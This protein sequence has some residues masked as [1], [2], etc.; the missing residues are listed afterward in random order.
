MAKLRGDHWRDPTHGHDC[1]GCDAGASRLVNGERLQRAH[2]RVLQED[3]VV[4][5]EER[6]DDEPD[7]DPPGQCDWGYCDKLATQWRWLGRPSGSSWNTRP[8]ATLNS[9]PSTRC[10]ETHRNLRPMDRAHPSP[11]DTGVNAEYSSTVETW[12]RP[13]GCTC[14]VGLP[15]EQKCTSATSRNVQRSMRCVG[16]IRYVMHEATITSDGVVPPRGSL[17]LVGRSD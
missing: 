11:V 2:V 14:D 7:D 15:R 16:R 1:P 9:K 4:S 17:R 3:R 12:K 6:R 10:C 8:P 13:T 5:Y